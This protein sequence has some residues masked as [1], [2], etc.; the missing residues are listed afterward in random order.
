M[1]PPRPGQRFVRHGTATSA[2]DGIKTRT[3]DFARDYELG[4]AGVLRELECCALG[5]D[6]IDISA[7]PHIRE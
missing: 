7:I 3:P 6:S 2:F 4:G 1:G 5:C